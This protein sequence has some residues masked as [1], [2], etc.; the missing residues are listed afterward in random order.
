MKQWRKAVLFR[1]VRAE[2]YYFRV[3]SHG[4][5]HKMLILVQTNQITR[6]AY[7]ALFQL[8]SA[9]AG[10]NSVQITYCFGWLVDILLTANSV[11]WLLFC[12]RQ[13]DCFATQ[14][15]M[16]LTL[17]FTLSKPNNHP[18]SILF[19][20]YFPFHFSSPNTTNSKNIQAY[21]CSLLSFFLY[22]QPSFTPLTSFSSHSTW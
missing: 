13:N 12:M 14:T 16:N 19:F 15:L 22:F 10:M 17:F 2:R 20:S 5:S 6:T 3:T 9:T 4:M 11:M 18:S 21:F 8:K 7:L 1:K